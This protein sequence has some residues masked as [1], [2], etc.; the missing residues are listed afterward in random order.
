MNQNYDN[1]IEATDAA[2]SVNDLLAGEEAVY[3]DALFDAIKA[4]LDGPCYENCMT[5]RRWMWAR[6]S[7]QN[8]VAFQAVL[9]AASAA[10]AVQ[11]AASEDRDA[12]RSERDTAIMLAKQA[13][14]TTT[15]HRT[16][17]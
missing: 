12:G 8:S 5:I 14:L 10:V 13:R 4:W 3:A 6:T 1:V 17:L 7:T 9:K 11:Y 2:K 16:D 15:D